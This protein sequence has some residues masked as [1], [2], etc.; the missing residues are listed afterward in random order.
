MLRTRSSVSLVF[1][2]YLVVG[3]I[4]AY[5]HG[6][7]TV[8]LLKSF[9]SALIAILLWFLILLGANLHLS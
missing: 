2:I 9:A 3:V 8:S 5:Q 4:V 1:L 6:Y 7:I